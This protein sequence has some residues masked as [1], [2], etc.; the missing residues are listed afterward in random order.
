MLR[1]APRTNRIFCSSITY[2]TSSSS[3]S[4]LIGGLTSYNSAPPRQ[5][6]N[7]I[8]ISFIGSRQMETTAAAAGARERYNTLADRLQEISHLEGISALLS[9][10]VRK[11]WIGRAVY[12]FD[13]ISKIARVPWIGLVPRAGIWR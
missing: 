9:W 2:A 1:V 8:R 5:T 3:T 10:Y 7:S 12:T 6:R 13:L 4:S 11:R